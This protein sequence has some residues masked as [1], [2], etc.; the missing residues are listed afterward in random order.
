MFKRRKLAISI[1]ACA[2][3]ALT[4]SIAPAT[5]LAKKKTTVIG[6]VTQS[7]ATTL[8]DGRVVGDIFKPAILVTKTVKNPKPKSITVKV[9]SVPNDPAAPNTIYVS[10][11]VECKKKPKDAISKYVVGVDLE[12]QP[13]PF[14]G[15]APFPF[16]VPKPAAC[17]VQVSSNVDTQVSPEPL[18]PLPAA[19][20][21]ITALWR[22]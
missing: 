7:N 12:K 2:V 16:G 17:R 14:S 8:P 6:K 3:A 1:L 19:T 5:T 10:G 22:H 18:A 11:I 20:I 4:L 9:T 21:T 13:S 15:K